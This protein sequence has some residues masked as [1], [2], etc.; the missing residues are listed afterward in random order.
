MSLYDGPHPFRHPR[1]Q[2]PLTP[3][4]IARARDRYAVDVLVLENYHNDRDVEWGVSFTN[5]NP[6]PGDYVEVASKEDAF[7]L[8]ALVDARVQT[9]RQGQ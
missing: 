2:R 5:H 8:K 9:A 3:E 1:P 6:E 4:V 7:R